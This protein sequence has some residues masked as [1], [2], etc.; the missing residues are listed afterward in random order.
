MIYYGIDPGS[1][2]CIAQLGPGDFI[3]FFDC[4]V[5]TMKSGRTRCS[6]LGMAQC[7]DGMWLLLCQN[8]GGRVTIEEVHAMPGNGSIASFGLGFSYGAWLGALMGC[9]LMSRTVGTVTPQRWKKDMIGEIPKDLPGS[10]KKEI[11]RL[12][13]I[14]LFPAAAEQ[15]KL[16]KHHNRA[17]ALLIAAWG[18]EHA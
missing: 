1:T 16:K 4:P 6:P 9:G 14:E 17:D 3:G 7:A 18:R 15:L 11:G 2:G 12:K 10:A 5:V 13:A 8:G